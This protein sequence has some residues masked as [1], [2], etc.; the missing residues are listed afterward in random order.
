MLRILDPTQDLV[1]ID[2]LFAPIKAELLFA[3]QND[4]N[5]SELGL[6]WIL[7]RCNS[8]KRSA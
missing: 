4:N 6:E 1:S 2:R 3:L 5:G 7:D 8:H